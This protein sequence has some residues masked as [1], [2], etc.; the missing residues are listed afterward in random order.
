MWILTRKTQKDNLTI[1]HK[2]NQSA[3]QLKRNAPE[4]EASR[5]MCMCVCINSSAINYSVLKR[6]SI[7]KKLPLTFQFDLVITSTTPESSFTY[8][9]ITTKPSQKSTKTWLQL[10]KMNYYFYSRLVFSQ[11]APIAGSLH[12]LPWP[13][14]HGKAGRLQQH[15]YPS[16]LVFVEL[17]PSLQCN[18]YWPNCYIVVCFLVP[19]T[20][21]SC[22][23]W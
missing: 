14:K 21:Y 5:Y 8:I 11:S 2:A 19:H 3:N 12:W 13:H 1:G 20:N 16:V 22:V 7:L 9:F 18:P 23:L 4:L 17:H 15:W 10:N 6:D